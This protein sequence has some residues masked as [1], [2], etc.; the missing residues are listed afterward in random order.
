V[1]AVF[2]CGK[3]GTVQELSQ[4][5]RKIFLQVVGTW[6]DNHSYAAKM[7]RESP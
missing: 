2:R 7:K 6:C 5:R 4:T 1:K 3:R